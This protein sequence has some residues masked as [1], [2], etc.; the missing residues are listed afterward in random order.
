MFENPGDEL[1]FG[2]VYRQILQEAWLPAGGVDWQRLGKSR[3]GRRPTQRGIYAASPTESQSVIRQWFSKCAAA[4]RLLP[5]DIDP[6]LDCDNRNPKKYWK[7]EKDRRGVQCSYYDL[8]MRYCLRYSLDHGCIPPA[9]YLLTI[10]PELIDVTCNTLY[11]LVFPNSCGSISMVSGDGEFIPPTDWLSPKCG[12]EGDLCFK[13]ANGS[14]GFIPYTFL[15]SHRCTE[16][17]W[18]PS[19]PDEMDPD[20]SVN[21]SI[22]G[23]VPPFHWIVSGT[24][25]SLGSSHTQE[26]DN[27]LNASSDSCGSATI[28]VIDSC[29]NEVTGFVRSTVGQWVLKSTDE[30]VLSGPYDETINTGEHRLT[31][32]NK[33]QYQKWGSVCSSY[34]G[35]YTCANPWICN[36]PGYTCSDHVNCVPVIGCD[37]CLTGDDVPIM[38]CFHTA[39]NSYFVRCIREL[40]FYLWEC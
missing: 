32:G 8:Y 34:G 17:T 37:P 28:L 40:L 31:L 29:D 3:R 11:P 25:F 14:L 36:S 12:D 2:E 6:P 13:D 10:E 5:W 23:G 38:G 9:N 24:H 35:D 27:T 39:P 26:R 30:C 16:Y 21:I 7:D 20:S 4:W 1:Y 22:L 33:R 18:P 15:P 19:N